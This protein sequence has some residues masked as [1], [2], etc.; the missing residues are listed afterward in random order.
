MKGITTSWKIFRAV[1]IV[2]MI[3]VAF[4]GMLSFSSL[5]YK[6]HILQSLISAVAYAF[7]FLFV[8]Q[9]LSILNYNYPDIPLTVKQKRSFNILYLVNFL[10]IAFLFAQVVN[11]WDVLP[12]LI[13]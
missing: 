12:V 5:F 6:T 10:L 11:T 8:Y 7:V 3:L 1:C 4:Q 13:Q 2:Q 9:G